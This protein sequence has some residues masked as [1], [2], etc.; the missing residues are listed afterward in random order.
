[1]I[2]PSVQSD[3]VDWDEWKTGERKEGGYFAGFNFVQKSAAG[4]TIMLTGFVLQLAG[5]VPNVEQTEASQLAIRTLYALFPLTC[6]L[7]GA[8]LF[9]RFSLGEKEHLQIREELE[10]RRR[11]STPV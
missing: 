8:V 11:A 7:I 2:A 5:Y 3:I 1:M 6:Y 9:L 10:A 4:V